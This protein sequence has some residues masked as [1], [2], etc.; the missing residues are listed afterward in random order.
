MPH[1]AHQR[2]GH[3]NLRWPNQCFSSRW[4]KTPQIQEY[5]ELQDCDQIQIVMI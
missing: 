1:Y 3:K 2:D 5:D 4:I